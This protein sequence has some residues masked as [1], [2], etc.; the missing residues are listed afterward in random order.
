MGTWLSR[1]PTNV[2]PSKQREQRGNRQAPLEDDRTR[3]PRESCPRPGLLHRA[4]KAHAYPCA[5][6]LRG[7]ESCPTL[8]G[9]LRWKE[10]PLRDARH[11]DSGLPSGRH[12]FEAT[13]GRAGHSNPVPPRPQ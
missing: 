5:T 3:W 11:A 7:P 12:A 13:A 1:A 6:H 9:C 10:D 2:A 4:R 8:T